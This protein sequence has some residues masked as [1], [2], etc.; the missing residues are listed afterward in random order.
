MKGKPEV[1]EILNSLIREEMTAISQYILHAE[2]YK[3]LGFHELHE[4]EEKASVEEMKHAEDLA[5]RILFLEGRPILN[6]LEPLRVGKTVPQMLENDR[7]LEQDAINRYNQAI[8]A[9]AALGDY[10]TKKLLSHILLD[11]EKH[12][13]FF[14]SEL[15]QIEQLTL[16]KYLIT[17]K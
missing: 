14:E 8:I 10:G 2:V 6:E 5:E 9:V 3:D 12:L 4:E 11:E 17:K 1:I 7:V 15:N 13:D 16:P